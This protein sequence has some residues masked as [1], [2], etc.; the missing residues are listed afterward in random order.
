ML[1]FFQKNIYLVDL[2]EGIT[3]FHNHILP[4]IDD[5]AKSIEESIGLIK[6]FENISIT[7]FVATPHVIGEYYPNTPQTISSAYQNLAKQL[8]DPS[9]IAYAAEYMM[10]QHFID[11]LENGEI[12]NIIGSKVLVEMSYFQPPLNLNEILFKIQNAS[13]SPI[14]AHPERYAFFHSKSLEKFKDLKSRGCD[15]QLNMLSL[16]GH[17]GL[18]IQKTAFQMLENKMIDF[19]C[20][21][22]HRIDHLEKIKKIKVPKK[23]SA[24]IQT[25]INNQKNLFS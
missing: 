2:I 13:Y 19:I 15:F 1:S 14:L 20:S 16:S 17:Y 24:G 12:L 8:E 5:G 6:A 11:I 7:N 3:D 9:R 21:D 10:D 22:V 23:F 4:G 25:V 18:G